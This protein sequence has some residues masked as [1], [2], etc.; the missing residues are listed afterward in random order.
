MDSTFEKKK[1]ALKRPLP[2]VS[3][4]VVA[5]T[6]ESLVISSGL[7]LL[8]IPLGSIARKTEEEDADGNVA[9]DLAL[10]RDAEIIQS[11]LVAVD[12]PKDI[13][14]G[15]IFEIISVDV[16]GCNCNCNCNCGSGSN[17]NC[18]CNCDCSECSGKPVGHPI[19]P[20]LLI[21]VSQFRRPVQ[22]GTTG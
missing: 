5:E 10:E 13:L 20:D 17:C 8:E 16:V 12:A 22:T 4:K 1:E 9:V 7:R 11:S 6:E 21:N 2:K 19:S 14:S 15:D 3:G 18:N